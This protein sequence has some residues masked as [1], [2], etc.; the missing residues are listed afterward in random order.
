[1]ENFFDDD[2]FYSNLEDYISDVF[3]WGDGDGS[4][5]VKN[6]PKNWSVKVELSD[7]EPMFPVNSD[8]LCDLYGEAYEDR[9][10]E[11]GDEYERVK[12][13][14]DQCIDFEKLN[15]MIPK[16][17]YPN[18]KYETITKQDLLDIL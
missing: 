4:D 16:L 17:Y 10:S 13:A 18:N 1:M 5:M 6:L 2:R 14:F 8:G 15:S 11:D 7:L 3:D 9:G 12:E